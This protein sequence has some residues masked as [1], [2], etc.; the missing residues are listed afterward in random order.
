MMTAR[1]MRASP[2]AIGALL[3]II[4][5]VC[6]EVTSAEA[7]EGESRQ[8]TIEE[9]MTMHVEPKVSN[10]EGLDP[11]KAGKYLFLCTFILAFSD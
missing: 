6:V 3:T 8:L 11:C 4:V 9:I 10:D 7:R 2:T 1:C 5:C